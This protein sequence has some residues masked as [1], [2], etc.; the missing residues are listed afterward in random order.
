MKAGFCT[1]I[2]VNSLSGAINISSLWDLNRINVNSFWW[3][4]SLIA[5]FVFK[6]RPWIKLTIS[7]V[8]GW[9]NEVLIGIP[10]LK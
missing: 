7:A 6:A 10:S 9:G 2:I 3:S 8:F 1:T 4:I 5:D